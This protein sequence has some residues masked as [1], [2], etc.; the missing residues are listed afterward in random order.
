[1]ADQRRAH[2]PSHPTPSGQPAE[3]DEIT[4]GFLL[5]VDVQRSTI[6]QTEIDAQDEDKES[7][8]LNVIVADRCRLVPTSDTGAQKHRDTS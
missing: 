4:V 8:V 1:M 7:G 5:A 2:G 3:L 6:G